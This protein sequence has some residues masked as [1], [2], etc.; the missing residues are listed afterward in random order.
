MDHAAEKGTYPDMSEA[1]FRKAMGEIADWMARYRTKVGELPVLSRT[2][3]GCL[4][5]A[6]PQQ[7]PASHEPVEMWLRDLEQILLPAV[8]HWNHPGFLAYRKH[9]KYNN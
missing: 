3:P 2:Q 4:E 8:T 7:A 1:E 6:L 9:R 5:K